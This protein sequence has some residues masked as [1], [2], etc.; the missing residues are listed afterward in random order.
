MTKKRLYVWLVMLTM[1]ACIAIEGMKVM[2]EHNM[3]Y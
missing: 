1:F 2:A 3:P